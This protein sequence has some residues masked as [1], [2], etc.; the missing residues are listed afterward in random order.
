MSSQTDTSIG[1][2]DIVQTELDE[3][4]NLFL[5]INQ[6]AV[7]YLKEENV[8]NNNDK[9]FDPCDPVGPISRAYS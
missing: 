8:P 4:Q 7:L 5:T 1:N 2:D 9:I 6:G 3:I